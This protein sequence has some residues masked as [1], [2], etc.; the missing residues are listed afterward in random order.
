MLKDVGWY[1]WKFTSSHSS[2][3]IPFLGVS[4]FL[5][6]DSSITSI[7]TGLYAK[8]KD[9]HQHLLSSSCHP[10]HTKPFHGNSFQSSSPFTM[11]L[12]YWP[13]VKYSGLLALLNLPLT[14]LNEVTTI[15]STPNKYDAPPTFPS[16]TLQ[17]KDVNKPWRMPLIHHFLISLTS[18]K[19]ITICCPLLNAA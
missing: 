19:T 1:P 6:N 16:C 12:F 10:F 4:V 13:Y 18:S 9:K 7:A 2:T 8:L 14:S 17:T 5:T 11:H 3:N 15:T